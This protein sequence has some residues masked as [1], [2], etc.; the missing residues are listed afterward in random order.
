MSSRTRRLGALLAISVL[1]ATTPIA[2]AAT[3]RAFCGDLLNAYGPFDY[4]KGHSEH[5]QQ[6]QLVEA[7][8]FNEDV[9]AG[10]KGLSTYIS[11]DLDYTLRA[12]PNH[13]RAL[14]TVSR[15]ALRDKA[16]VL[17]RGTRP[18]ECYFDRA[19]RFAPDDPAVYALYGSYLYGRN[20]DDDRKKAIDKFLTA[21]SFDP[22]NS[23]IHYNAGLAL[24][25]GGR[26][27]EAN[28]H[29]QMAYALGFPLPGLKNMLIKAGAWDPDAP[30]LP[31]VPSRRVDATEEDKAEAAPAATPP[32]PA[33]QSDTPPAQPPATPA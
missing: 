13:A 2:G 20:K 26:V 7:G 16:V 4:R 21:L 10:I 27:R 11:G 1:L 17:A 29:A 28:Q 5:K 33:E 32:A 30:P 23:S 22:G 31:Q 24:F 12:F 8:H 18:V 9:E 3:L 15:L 6:L 25:T 14:A 19:E